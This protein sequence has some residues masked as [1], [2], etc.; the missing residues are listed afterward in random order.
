MILYLLMSIAAAAQLTLELE[1]R[2]MVVGQTVPLTLQLVNGDV[3]GRPEIPVGDG[4]VVQFSG[5][6]SQTVAV[7]F[8]TT[9]VVRFSYEL[10][11]VRA[12]DWAVGPVDLGTGR[13]A[14]HADALVVSVGNAPEEQGAA[15]VVASVSDAE[16]V[17]GQVVV[18]RFQFRH[19]KP[20]VDARW[21]QPAFDGFVAEQLAESTQREYQIEE[22]GE[23]FTVQTIDVPLVAAGVG[24]RSIPPAV[25]TAKYRDKRRRRSNRRSMDDLFRDSPFGA[26]GGVR[27]VTH[28]TDSVPVDIRPL[29]DGAPANFSGLVG[30][31]KITVKAEERQ[32]A[33]G[34]SV[35]LEYRITGDGT[36]A[37]FRLPSPDADAA[38]RVYD[39]AAEIK[40]QVRD[41]RFVSTA[42]VRR[43]VVPESAGRLRIDALRIPIFNP[44]SGRYE[45]V[46][47]PAVRIQVSP[48]DE[49]AGVVSSYAD[50]GETK[51]AVTALGEDVLPVTTPDSVGDATLQGAWP[52][53]LGL[54]TVPFLT[55]LMALIV[56]WSARRRV[57]PRVALLKRLGDLPAEP[58]A[59]L[60]AIESIFLEL[61][62]L[63]VGATAPSVDRGIVATLGEEP[64]GLY[65]ALVQ[66][67]YG[68]VQTSLDGLFTRVLGFAEASE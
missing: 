34:E 67:R 54:P 33:L 44:E 56:G 20:L 26:V 40:A 59:R 62:G 52:V 13:D 31:F 50:A 51:R 30:R 7:N 39:D 60:A 8:R 57:D 14:L 68:G 36:L 49:G 18:Y 15:P 47:A 63:R 38:F 55:W 32:L 48:G 58:T 23:A 17:L 3:R 35:T 46:A 10:R 43:A 45:V 61:V 9:E 53:V 29:P 28:A 66:A 37:G 1:G 21:S 64:L 2:E 42:L 5:R 4:L 24:G 16:P 22:A 27:T 6:S 41:G 19:D 12:G 65:D 11:A 25:L